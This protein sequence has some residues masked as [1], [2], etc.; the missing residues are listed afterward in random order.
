MAD[1]LDCSI[2]SFASG[3]HSNTETQH[4]SESSS[5]CLRTPA[6]LV[7]RSL[8][9]IVWTCFF[10]SSQ[11]PLLLTDDWQTK[12]IKSSKRP[13]GLGPAEL[14]PR[15]SVALRPW[16][17]ASWFS[18]GKPG[19]LR[20]W[21]AIYNWLCYSHWRTLSHFVIEEGAQLLPLLALVDNIYLFFSL[22]CLL[23]PL[24][25]AADD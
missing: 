13:G 7:L 23:S 25:G 12:I 2:M 5:L 20:G 14:A 16:P 10:F 15:L 17:M 1:S 18:L 22:C 9:G 6:S 19:A 8:N 4:V 21:K 3:W 11:S 24:S